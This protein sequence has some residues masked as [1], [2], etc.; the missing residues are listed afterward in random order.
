[1]YQELFSEPIDYE[2]DSSFILSNA[3]NSKDNQEYKIK[4]TDKP[5][6]MVDNIELGFDYE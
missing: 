1:M 4:G 2:H 5:A 6:F 3:P